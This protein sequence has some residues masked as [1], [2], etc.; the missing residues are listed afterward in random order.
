MGNNR[1][2]ESTA[3]VTS[4]S[5]YLL[6]TPSVS[7]DTRVYGTHAAETVNKETTAYDHECVDTNYDVH[8]QL[9]VQK[10]G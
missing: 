10:A 4:V 7:S 2:P 5:I 1:N 9:E 6:S 3:T 8:N